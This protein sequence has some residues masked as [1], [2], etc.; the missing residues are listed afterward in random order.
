M[1]LCPTPLPKDQRVLF[2]TCSTPAFR[3]RTAESLRKSGYRLREVEAR[4]IFEM[5]PLFDSKG[6]AF[7]I[8]EAGDDREQIHQMTQHLYSTWTE[9]GCVTLFVF[10]PSSFVELDVWKWL[11]MEEHP[12]FGITKFSL[13][14]EAFESCMLTILAI[15]ARTQEPPRSFSSPL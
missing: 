5:E 6:F 8:I 3:T 14:N 1:K 2:L 12:R 7:F 15:L 13:S 9:A 10:W 4:S 11:G